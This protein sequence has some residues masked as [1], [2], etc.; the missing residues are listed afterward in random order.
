[1]Y[2]KYLFIIVLPDV[3]KEVHLVHEKTWKAIPSYMELHHPGLDCLRSHQC[4]EI[5][6]DVTSASFGTD[7]WVLMSVYKEVPQ[8]LPS[9]T[10]II[11]SVPFTCYLILCHV[12]ECGPGSVVSIVTGYRLDGP[13]I[14]SQWGWDFPHLSRLAPGAHPAPCTM[15]T[16]SFLGVKSGQGMTLTPHPLLVPWSRTTIFL[17]YYIVTGYSDLLLYL[18]QDC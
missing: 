16:R 2:S 18:M 17:L 15:G 10:E 4:W 1:M 7:D 14:E 11:I 8:L 13:G 3:A 12:I 5:A 9:A 6:M